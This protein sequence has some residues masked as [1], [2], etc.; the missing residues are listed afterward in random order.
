MATQERQ[1][2]FVDKLLA[3]I[4][5]GLRTVFTPQT[6]SDRESPASD[7]DEPTMT[8]AQRKH[9]EGLMRI[10]H[11]GEIC[12]QALY[13]G[14][15]LTAKLPEVRDK[16]D[17]SAKEEVDHLVWCE[18]RINELDGHT[19]YLNP[20]WYAGSFVMGATAG[21]LGDKWSLGFVAET[22]RQVVSHL[23]HHLDRLP[24]EDHKSRKILEQMREDEALHATLADESGAA[25]LPV[26]VK[27]LMSMTSKVMTKITYWV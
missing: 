12:A 20:L 25:R 6:E 10:D 1:Y 11:A 24:D 27:S 15:A 18:Q 4:D 7:M 23:N 21:L 8:Q 22:E 26:P 19:S 17:H 2:S 3:N 5:E 9:V 13:R 14:Q 16:M